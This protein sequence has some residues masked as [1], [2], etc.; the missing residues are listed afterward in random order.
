MKALIKNR[1]ALPFLVTVSFALLILANFSREPSMLNDS[2]TRVLLVALAKRS[3]PLS[4]FWGDW[5]LENHFYR[6]IS[7]LFFEFDAHFYGGNAVGFGFTNAAVMFLCS[8]CVFWLARELFDKIWLAIG[9]GVLSVG[10]SIGMPWHLLEW[11]GYAGL[12]TALVGAYRHRKNLLVYLVPALTWLY[13]GSELAGIRGIRFRTLEW[14]PGRTATTMTLFVL[15][16]MAAYCRYVRLGGPLPNDRTPGPLDPPATRTSVQVKSS[17]GRGFWL[18]VSILGAVLAFGAYEQAVMVPA[19]LLGCG[20]AFHLQRYR[21]NWFVHAAFWSILIGYM[22]L[23]HEVIPP[24]A[25]SYQSQQ[26]R[27]GPGVWLSLSDFLFPFLG[28]L[29]AAGYL[30]E[31]LPLTLFTSQLYSAILNLLSQLATAAT[32]GRQW[33]ICLFGYV[34]SFVAFLPMAWLQSF[35]HYYYLPMLLRTIFV[36]GLSSAL[37]SGTVTAWSRPAR[38]APPRLR[39]AAGSLL[40]P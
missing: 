37:L 16:A 34:A 7:T 13:I 22:V 20:L 5:P 12:L 3:N 23:R 6:P 32:A 35:D 11:L 9:C 17:S 2:D 36:V 15:I 25:S 19:L 27:Y 40:R 18:V 39:P 33:L 30:I 28:A 31:G 38:Q 8:L 4:W 1:Y 10:Y 29:P 24:N 14:L 21:I 26:L